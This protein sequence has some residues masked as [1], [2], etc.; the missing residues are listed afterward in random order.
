MKKVY[1]YFLTFLWRASIYPRELQL[2][3]ANTSDKKTC[4]F[5]LKLVRT[6]LNYHTLGTCS[7]AIFLSSDHSLYATI[8]LA[9]TPCLISFVWDQSTCLVRI[10]SEKIQNEKLL[11]TVVFEPTTLIFVVRCSNDWATRNLLKGV[12]FKWSLYIHVLPIPMYT[13]A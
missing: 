12:L 10:E 13:M 8:N 3:K 5:D 4:F 9:W 1:V 2:N 11:S 7:A 6:P